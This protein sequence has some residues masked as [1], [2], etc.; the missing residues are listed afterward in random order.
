MDIKTKIATEIALKTFDKVKS[1][2]KWNEFIDSEIDWKEAEK[3]I[4]KLNLD[5]L[6][7]D[8]SIEDKEIE[9]MIKEIDI[10]LN[11]V[12]EMLQQTETRS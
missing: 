10:E 5:I 9:R 1:S 11:K 12:V 6:L 4:P 2:D 8:I 7:D 3:L